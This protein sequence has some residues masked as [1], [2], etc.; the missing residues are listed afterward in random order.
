MATSCSRTFNVL[1]YF[2]T[3]GQ[4]WVGTGQTCTFFNDRERNPITNNSCTANG[5]RG[6]AHTANLERQQAK[7]VTAINTID[8]DIVSLEE[9]EN[10]VALGEANRDDALSAS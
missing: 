9:I 3:T 7:I 10:S 4:A 8:A 5:P 2:T 1:N 6:A